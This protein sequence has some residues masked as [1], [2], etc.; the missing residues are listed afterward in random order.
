MPYFVCCTC[1]EQFFIV[2]R[3]FD[4]FLEIVNKRIYLICNHYI[5]LIYQPQRA[6][7]K[8][9]FTPFAKGRRGLPMNTKAKFVETK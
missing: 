1:I 6:L 4:F 3:K 2:Q 9:L 5:E 7:R 8:L